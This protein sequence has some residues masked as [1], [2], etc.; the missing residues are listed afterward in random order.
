MDD[1]PIRTP[2][3]TE[4]IVIDEH[5]AYSS[6]ETHPES[7]EASVADTSLTL[8]DVL[9]VISNRRRRFVLHYLQQSESA[10]TLGELSTQIAAWELDKPLDLVSSTERKNV[11]NALA[12]TH[13]RRLRETGF[14]LERRGNIELTPEAQA[15]RIHID[16]VPNR[17]IPW[18]K[19]YFGLGLFG[20]AASIGFMIFAPTGVIP[21]GGLGVFV[22]VSVLV[23]AA[24]HWHYKRRMCLGVGNQPP[25]LRYERE[26]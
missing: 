20:L 23:S 2:P 14:I 26:A 15:I 16:I 5:E 10:T 6:A 7:P 19:Y 25:E 9:T 21:V 22:A 8:T 13:V 4:P 12:Q 1:N 11:Y 17:D 3:T 24:A 18:S